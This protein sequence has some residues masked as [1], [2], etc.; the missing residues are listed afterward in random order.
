MSVA[1]DLV[2]V[3]SLPERARRTVSPPA[4]LADVVRLHPLADPAPVRLTRRGVAVVVGLVAALG[5]GLV[6]LA[7]AS[8]PGADA[9]TAHPAV[10]SVV[11]GDTLWAIA[12]RVAPDRDPRAEVAALERANHLTSPTLLPGQL[13]R[14]P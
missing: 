5:A 13:L 1:I 14:I 9:G 10:V 2:P 7:A 4:P 3:V 12:A 8:A 11:P 6:A